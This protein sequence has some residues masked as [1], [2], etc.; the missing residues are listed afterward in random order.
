MKDHIIKFNG[1]DLS[2]RFNYKVQGLTFAPGG[3][4]IFTIDLPGKDGVH[5]QGNAINS[6]TAKLQLAF[7]GDTTKEVYTNVGSFLSYMMEIGKCTMESSRQAGYIKY[8]ELSTCEEYT[9][10]KGEDI[11]YA[12]VDME[13]LM[14]DPYTYSINSITNTFGPG[15]TVNISITNNY[16]RT[17]FK[18][19]FA[20]NGSSSTNIPDTDP[21]IVLSNNSGE[22]F[23][24][25]GN[26]NS[27]V[28]VDTKEY[29]VK[30][31]QGKSLIPKWEG[32]MPE[33]Q[34]GTNTFKAQCFQSQI[35]VTVEYLERML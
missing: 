19:K 28:T 26:F 35:T 32:D 6:G 9:V 16:T 10:I 29:T 5:T 20:A 21:S 3:K 33:L 23:R 7:Y 2:T 4:K 22:I 24:I 14:A 1:V 30:D 18:I 31:G 13:F 25:K 8:V 27:S 34:H 12:A 11:C 17:P 15:S